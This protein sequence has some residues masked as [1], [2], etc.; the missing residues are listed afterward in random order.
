MHPA[1]AA[2]FSTRLGGVSEGPWSSLNLGLHVGD[3]AAA[4]Q[5]NRRRWL[6]ALG[7]PAQSVLWLRQAHG[8]EVA[9]AGGAHGRPEA[10]PEADAAVTADAGVTLAVLVADC[11]PVYLVD[12]EARV[13]ALAHA[14]WRGTAARIAARAAGVMA[15][16]FGARPE[17][18]RAWIGPHIRECCY[19]VDAPVI[20]RF[21][22]AFGAAADAFLRP[23]RPG[24][25][26]L[27]LAGA[28]RR[29]L[30]EAGVPPAHV[31]ESP[32]CTGCRLD[33]FYSHRKEGGRTGRMAAALWL[34]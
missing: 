30:A 19:E 1:A 29:A 18:M 3:E 10:P 21:R 7:R 5:E 26:R 34:R 24:H 15:G 8:A 25:A 22:E 6:E 2:S 28:I 16:R 20:D 23:A 17:R 14:G 31:G 9:V 32:E 4:V 12:P 11:A 33:L 13:A 27:S